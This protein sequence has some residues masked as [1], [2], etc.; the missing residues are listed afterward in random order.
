MEGTIMPKEADVSQIDIDYRADFLHKK[1]EEGRDLLAQFIRATAI[2]IA[3]TGAILKFALDNNA[4]PQLRVALILFGVGVSL[5]AA[6]TCLM[7]H[8]IRKA[9]E[10]DILSLLAELKQISLKSNVLALKY[11]VNLT[12]CLVLL[13]IVGW[14][15]LLCI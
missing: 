8:K 7:S 15:Y 14:V 13:T 10:E 4:T 9:L 12:L 11:A 2:F 3:L 5:L 1:L 6:I